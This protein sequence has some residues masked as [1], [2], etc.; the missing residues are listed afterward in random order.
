[1]RVLSYIHAHMQIIPN[2][3]V[4]RKH[5]GLHDD[6]RMFQCLGDIFIFV[7]ESESEVSL[8]VPQTGTFLCHSGQRKVQLT[9]KQ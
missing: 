8:F 2:D 5:S 9:N 4:T 7:R 3:N 6:N 1:M